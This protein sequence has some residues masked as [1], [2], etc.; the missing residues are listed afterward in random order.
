MISANST[1]V[2]GPGVARKNGPSFIRRRS[3]PVGGVLTW[4]DVG[5]SRGRLGVIFHPRARAINGETESTWRPR[6]GRPAAC[7]RRRAAALE[8]R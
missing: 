4:D 7:D 1:T 6:P 5:A 3:F 2:T 8:G